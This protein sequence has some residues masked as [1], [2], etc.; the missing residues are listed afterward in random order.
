M[1]VA[2]A[3]GSVD[4]SQVIAGIDWVVEHRN[5]PGMNIR[6]LNLSFGTDGVQDYMLDPLTYA[7]EV[8]WRAG[9]RRGGGGRQQR[10]RPPA[11]QRPGL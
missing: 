1:K 9:H 8:A 10:H 11:A 4:V 6:V 5:D 7:A 3:D 2:T